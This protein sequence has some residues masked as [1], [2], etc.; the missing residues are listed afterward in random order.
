VCWLLACLLGC[1]RS[2]RRLWLPACCSLHCCWSCLGSTA[3]GIKRS[4]G[5]GQGSARESVMLEQLLKLGACSKW[6]TTGQH[7]VHSVHHRAF[8]GYKCSAEQVQLVTRSRKGLCGAQSVL[9]A[10]PLVHQM[11]PAPSTESRMRIKHPCI[12]PCYGTKVC[13][14]DWTMFSTPSRTGEYQ[15]L[16][17]N[18]PVVL[19]LLV[20][21]P[22]FSPLSSDMGSSWAPTGGVERQSS[23]LTSGRALSSMGCTE[24]RWQGVVSKD[25]VCCFV[26]PSS[27]RNLDY[28]SSATG[29]AADMP[30]DICAEHD[31][32][33]HRHD[34]W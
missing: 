21:W 23:A 24:R 10:A 32:C 20:V 18:T 5:A 22:R 31:E 7:L 25:T 30:A 1:W 17:V 16:S 28:M 2:R 11:S 4:G 26:T 12:H 19:L 6:R 34:H 9:S 15:Q 3:E 27:S 14:H 8:N 29:K 13:N 33:C